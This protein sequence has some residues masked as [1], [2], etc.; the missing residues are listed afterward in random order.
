MVEQKDWSSPYLIKTTKL[1]PNAEQRST[2]WTGNF[3]KSYPTPE[4]EEEV[5]SR[6]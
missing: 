4:V 3:Q 6:W 1:Q 2:K 5:T